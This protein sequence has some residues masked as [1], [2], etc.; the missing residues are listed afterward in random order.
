M[1][2]SSPP[3]TAPPRRC[4]SRPTTPSTSPASCC[5]STAATSP[6]DLPTPDPRPRP[7]PPRRAHMPDEQELKPVT[8]GLD[9]SLFGD[10]HVRQYED[11][12]GE[13]GYLWNGAPCLVLTTTGRKTGATRKIPIIFGTDGDD[14]ILIGSQGGAPTHPNWY[15]NLV[16]DPHGRVQIKGDRYDVVATTVEGPE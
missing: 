13:V 10:E 11:T 16:A 7:R 5:P 3:R 12:D 9:L 4:S 6:A 15:L 14:V 1:A 8:A 2:A